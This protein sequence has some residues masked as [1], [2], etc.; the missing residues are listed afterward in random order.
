[1]AATSM[2][3]MYYRHRVSIDSLPGYR[4]GSPAPAVP[5]LTSYKI[6]SNENPYPPL[7]GVLQTISEQALGHLNRYP[8]MHGTRLVER[9][10]KL[11]GVEPACI[12][13]GCGSTE[14]ITQLVDLVAGHG[15]QVVYPWRSF[16]AYPIIITMAGATGVPVP[17][18]RQGRHD[19]E[20]MI[21]AV[22]DHTRLVIVNNPNNPTATSVDLPV[23]FDEA[24]VQFNDDPDRAD[25]LSLMREHPNVIAARTFSK[26]YGLAGLRIGYAVAAEPIIAGMN[27]VALP[28]GV[29]DVAQTA[30]MAS[31]DAQDRLAERVQALKQER[32]RILAGLQEQGWR[33]PEPRAN[34]YW[35]PLGQAA[36]Q[37]DQ[38][39]RDVGL[40]VRT[41]P[42]E[43]V[44][45]TVGEREANDRVLEV[46]T[47]L[48][49]QGLP[50]DPIPD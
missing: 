41:F 50:Q 27:K 20:A 26:A 36:A 21:A 1:M 14:V 5:G 39:F 6:S 24:Y 31:L 13:L 16:E 46:C 49:R 3:P 38:R 22:N 33:I 17:L 30:A 48:R 47:D 11:H 29:T 2:V 8:D 7:P 34:Y 28:F 43:G 10:A 12:Q 15:D 44:R 37:A 19:I 32:A 42:G 4:Q 40:S 9:L 23:L 25:G 45:I 18:D 35:L